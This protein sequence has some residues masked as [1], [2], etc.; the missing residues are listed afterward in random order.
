MFSR[1]GFVSLQKV[2]ESEPVWEYFEIQ[3]EAPEEFRNLPQAG[4]ASACP[5]VF[6]NKRGRIPWTA[7]NQGLGNKGAKGKIWG[8]RRKPRKGLGDTREDSV[9]KKFLFLDFFE[10]FLGKGGKLFHGL[11]TVVLEGFF[12]G[13]NSWKILAQLDFPI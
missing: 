9:R 5:W 3:G 6:G 4:A 10:F 11:T 8:R 2:T 7:W 12:C 1:G 13:E